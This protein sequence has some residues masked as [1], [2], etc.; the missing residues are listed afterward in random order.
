MSIVHTFRYPL[1]GRAFET[2]TDSYPLDRE[3]RPQVDDLHDEELRTVTTDYY[4]LPIAKC[5]V[6]V[7]DKSK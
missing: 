7:R 2:T 5:D 1:E 3:Q 4:P 6:L